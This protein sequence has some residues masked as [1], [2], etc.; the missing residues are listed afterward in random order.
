[1]AIKTT[2]GSQGVV[3]EQ[4]SGEDQLIINAPVQTSRESVRTIVS[5]SGTVSVGVGTTLFIAPEEAGVTASLP[6]LGN[7]GV[8]VRVLLD[9][10]DRT[11]QISGSNGIDGTV[12]TL[13]TSGSYGVVELIGVKADDDGLFNWTILTHK[14]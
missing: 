13:N 2:I 9:K 8:F 4:V 1:M 12:Y 11:I 3:S 14:Q 10:N 6:V 7:D 5:A